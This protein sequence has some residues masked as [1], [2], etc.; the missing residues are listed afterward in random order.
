VATTLGYLLLVPDATVITGTDTVAARFPAPGAQQ[1]KAVA[2][3]FRV[4]LENLHPLARQG[5]WVGLALGA[6]FALTERARPDWKKW[7]P[8]ATGVGFGLMLPFST[9]LSFLLGALAAEVF[10]HLSRVRAERY[11]V[12]IASGVIAG[13]SILGV[14]VAA[15]NTFVL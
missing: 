8:S 4:G 11:V 3:V 13:E 7:L 10:T 6:V 5:I 1:W 15:L 12:P 14:V 2:D 9:P